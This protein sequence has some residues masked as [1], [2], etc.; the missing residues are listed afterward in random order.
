MLLPGLPAAQQPG[1]GGPLPLQ[2]HDAQDL[3]F[4]ATKRPVMLRLYVQIDGRPARAVRDEYVR[5]WL[6]HFDRNGDG[7]LNKEEARY[8]PGT[9]IVR[10]MRRGG[11]VLDRGAGTYATMADLDPDGDG[12]VTAEELVRYFDRSGFEPFQM[13]TAPGVAGRFDPPSEV[14][15]KQ[16]DVKKEGK[17][18]R[19]GVKQAVA[20]L[21][22][23]LQ[24]TDDEIL[25]LQDLGT[26]TAPAGGFGGGGIQPPAKAQP[27]PRGITAFHLVSPPHLV[28]R[29]L[30]QRLLTHYDRND[31]QRLSLAESGLDRATFDRL[32]TDRD[33]ALDNDELARWNQ[34]SADLEIIIRLGKRE[35]NEGAVEIHHLG[36]KPG[37]LASAISKEAEGALRLT[38]GDMQ[39]A[40]QG[41][42]RVAPAA[43]GVPFVQ[44]LFQQADAQNRGFV[45]LKDLGTPQLQILRQMFPVVDRD[46]DGKMTLKEL[47]A[48]NALQSEARNS[49]VTIAVSEQ[50]R[51]LFRLVDTNQDSRLGLRELRTL[52]DRLAKLDANGDGFVSQ[53]EVARLFQAQVSQ[54]PSVA[55]GRQTIIVDGRV[56][57]VAAP[58]RLAPRGPVWF[59]GMDRNGDGDVSLREFL[60][61]REEFRRLDT[62]GDGLIGLEEAERADA[63]LRKKE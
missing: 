36:G 11:F 41:T 40:V 57:T 54:G 21:V 2:A 42:L 33:G 35:R 22:K 12:K 18:S 62:D 7:V 17:L 20:A 10:D 43:G 26:A 53:D 59:R 4:F 47:D 8:V 55:A 6:Q 31:D 28:D 61:S 34:Q 63:A 60:G 51:A 30:A 9:I 3:A 19:E 29:Q 46:G 44:V 14:L 45:E 27:G 39:L 48:F 50:G 38:L 56:V 15:W 25:T 58:P 52:W 1:G 37:P 5:K 13:T 16:L 24:A 49:T 23:R 32:D